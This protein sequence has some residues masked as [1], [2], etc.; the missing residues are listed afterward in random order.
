MG[1]DMI[2]A[3]KS[4]QTTVLLVDDEETLREIGRDLLV[5]HGFKVLLAG[6]GEKAIETYRSNRDSIQVV[7]LDL[8]MPGMS[9]L[10]CLEEL[11]KTDPQVKIIAVSGYGDSM[12]SQELL[13][14]GARA[15]VP[16]PYKVEVMVEKIRSLLD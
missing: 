15:F 2:A 11:V 5:S 14:A 9:G 7:I 10:V 13:K 16:K 4:R 1:E 8:I 3:G 12:R 6:S